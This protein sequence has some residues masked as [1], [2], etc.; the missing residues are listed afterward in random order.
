MADDL[1]SSLLTLIDSSIPSFQAAE[2]LLFFAANRDR[3]FSAEEV[4]V[5]MRPRVITVAAVRACAE[6]FTTRRLVTENEGRFRYR[7]ASSELE[8]GVGELSREYNE[9]P[10]TLITAIYRVADRSLHSFADFHL[11][12]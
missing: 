7:P 1:S 2:A 12:D 8:R 6:L 5:G 9:R 11:R 4:V 10:V 3:D